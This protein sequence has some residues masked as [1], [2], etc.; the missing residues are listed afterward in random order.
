MSGVIYIDEAGNTGLKD[1]TQ[2]YLMYGGVYVTAAKSR[3]VVNDL[4]ATRVKYEHVLK[5]RIGNVDIANLDIRDIS[6]Q[7]RFF[8]H[9]CFH[10]AEI[11]HGTGLWGK[12]SHPERLALIEEL[13]GIIGDNSLSFY[14]AV[15]DKKCY[16]K[17]HP[18]RPHNSE[19]ACVMDEFLELIQQDL[20]ACGQ[21][22]LIIGD[23][24]KEEE[25][26]T[27]TERLQNQSLSCIHC[28]IIHQRRFDRPLLQ[29][30][31]VGIWLIQGIYRKREGLKSIYE[32]LE[33]SLKLVAC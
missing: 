29:V 21:T 9:F 22:G 16:L 24:G 12:L 28:D 26:R 2:P 31:D 33:P 5:S 20:K 3:K 7:L 4:Y 32:V 6:A 23:D 8:E 25:K 17:K 14:I 15:L 11:M 10:A 18:H 1:L 13:I 30:A 19:Y 27:I